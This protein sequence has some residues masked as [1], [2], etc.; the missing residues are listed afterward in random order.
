MYGSPNT[1]PIKCQ[2]LSIVSISMK[3]EMRSPLVCIFLPSRIQFIV[4]KFCQIFRSLNNQFIQICSTLP[5]LALYMITDR[6]HCI[7]PRQC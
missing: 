6:K 2:Y 5:V 7:I 3:Q 4:V 1:V